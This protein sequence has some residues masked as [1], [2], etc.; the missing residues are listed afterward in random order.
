MYIH[1]ID[2]NVAMI[3]SE[4]RD[5]LMSLLFFYIPICSTDY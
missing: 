5:D 3:F 4:Q 1:V 2:Y